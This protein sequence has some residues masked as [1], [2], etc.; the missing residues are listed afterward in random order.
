MLVSPLSFHFF[1]LFSFFSFHSSSPLT[2]P[3]THHGRSFLPFFVSASFDSFPANHLLFIPRFPSSL[4]AFLFTPL[5]FVRIFPYLTSPWLYL[6][7][8][9]PIQTL[10]F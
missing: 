4:L 10:S 8:F 9:H 3:L 5:L 6:P 2:L 1:F 7:S